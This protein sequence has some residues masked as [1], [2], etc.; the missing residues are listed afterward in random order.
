MDT[1]KALR[2][3][4]V[5]QLK[6]QSPTDR[7]HRN[8]AVQKKLRALEAYKKARLVFF[9]VS[10]P[11]EVDTHPLIDEALAAGKRVAVPASDLKTKKL[12]FYEIADR[13]K[14]LKLGVFDV[15][16]PRPE[17]TKPV[18]AADAECVLVPGVVFDRKNRRIGH[19]A[20]F[21]DRF[22]KEIGAGVPK[23][24]LAFSFQMLDEVPQED[25]D[26]ALDR[27]LTD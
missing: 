14:H 16:E 22:L 21:Y 20:G 5:E 8:L 1:K 12:S 18:R 6:S 13:E 23:I 19:G 2:Q 26:V 25:H 27:V 10:R 3:R 9:Y 4:V 15:L 17:L 11:E 7:Q 24:G